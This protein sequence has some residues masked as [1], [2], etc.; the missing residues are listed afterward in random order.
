MNPTLDDLRETLESASAH[1]PDNARRATDVHRRIRRGNRVRLAAGS[2]AAV[3][4]VTIGVIA[5]PPSGDESGQTGP[6]YTLTASDPVPEPP[7][8]RWGMPRIGARRFPTTGKVRIRFTPTGHDT[9]IIIRCA[10]GFTAAQWENGLLVGSGPCAP[11]GEV[12]GMTSL[13]TRTAGPLKPGKPVM[14]E[15]GLAKG[16]IPEDPP[17]ADEEAQF[18]R[19]LASQPPVTTSWAIAVYSGECAGPE[20]AD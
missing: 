5:L 15:V 2:A 12:L 16:S 11:E 13:S 3:S 20:C 19:L 10:K 1:L 18:T 7:M 17:S 9:L 14:L 8:E 6:V 4:A